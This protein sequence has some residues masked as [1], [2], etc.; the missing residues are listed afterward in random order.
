MIM[1]CAMVAACAMVALAACAGQKPS[2]HYAAIGARLD[3][4]RANITPPLGATTYTLGP[5]RLIDLP[6]GENTS[7]GASLLQLP[8]VSLG[9]N[10]QVPVRDQ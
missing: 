6:A 3:Q 10:G 9:L 4:A 1:T 2:P 5:R 7:L 8:G